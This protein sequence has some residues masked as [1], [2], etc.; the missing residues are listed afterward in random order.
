LNQQDEVLAGNHTPLL[1]HYKKT[2]ALTNRSIFRI[3]KD[4]LSMFFEKRNI[5]KPD[6]EGETRISLQ[7][8]RDC[9]YNAGLCRLLNSDPE[10]GIVG[11]PADLDRRQEIFGKHSIAIPTI[12]PMFT[13]MARQFEDSNVI[14]LTKAATLYLIVSLF[15]NDKGA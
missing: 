12:T 11:D 13:I 1:S 9:G 3:K 10:T 8:L 2:P 14:F 4:E 15:G 7:I 6:N 5:K